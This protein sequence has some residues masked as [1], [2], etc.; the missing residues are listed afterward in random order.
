MI[1]TAELDRKK[2]LL[3]IL[4]IFVLIFSATTVLAENL[5]GN[6]TQ[7]SAIQQTEPTVIQTVQQSITGEG[8]G[9]GKFR[10][11]PTVRIRP[12]NDMI[13]KSADGLIEIYLDNPNVNDIPLTVDVHISVPSGLHIYGQGFGEAVAAGILYAKLHVPPGTVRTAYINI[14]AEKTGNY[15]AQ[16]SGLYYP[17]ENKDAYQPISLTYP[18]TVY[19]PSP[20]PKSQKLTNPN[21]VPSM[22]GLGNNIYSA[23]IIALIAGLIGLGYKI[24][25]LRYAHR[26]Q[27]QR[28]T[29]TRTIEGKVTESRTTDTETRE[30]K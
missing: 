12:L 23:I 22:S 6:V 20:D 30:G 19:E 1:Y 28:V 17:G 3:R 8:K 10:A 21:Q 15:Y 13:N 5:Q 4:S 26:L 18:F 16:F 24:V 7:Q 27:T 9:E 25:E 14:K 29:E 11:G 2:M